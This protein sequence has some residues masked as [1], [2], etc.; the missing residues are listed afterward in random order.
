MVFTKNDNFEL[1]WSSVENLKNTQDVTG[2]R[3]ITK[4][5]VTTKIL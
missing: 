2:Y 4:N 3:F 1:I 5:Y